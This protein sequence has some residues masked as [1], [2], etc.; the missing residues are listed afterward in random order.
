MT[1]L[2]AT[3][4]ER[5][6]LPATGTPAAS[7]GAGVTAGDVLAMLRRRAVMIIL[8][9]LPF[10]MVAVGLFFLVYI[11]F[12][13]YM[14]DAWVECLSDQPKAGQQL[15]QQALA[16]DL[17][18]RFINSQ[19]QLITSSEVLNAA[20]KT[21]EVRGT[22][23]FRELD[24]QERFLALQE[25]IGAG[26]MKN[27]NYLRVAMRCRAQTDPAV[28][29]RQVVGQFLNM[30]QDRAKT[31]FREELK[32]YKNEEADLAKRIADKLETIKAFTAT[33]PPG[34]LTNRGGIV[35]EQLAI[36]AEQVAALELQTMELEGLSQV[37]N[38]PSGPGVSAEDRQ[39]V[40]RDPMVQNL[41][42]QLFYIEQQYDILLDKFGTEHRQVKALAR[43]RDAVNRQLN[44][45]R[46]QRL[47]DILDFRREQVRTAFLNS[48]HALLLARDKL[49][50]A[51]AAQ[52]DLDRKMSELQTLQDELSALKEARAQTSA[53]VRDIERVVAD[54]ETIR[55][56]LAQ[57]A[58]DPLKRSSPHVMWLPAGV[59]LAFMFAV[60]LAL[61]L[62]FTDTSV[63]TPQDIVRHLN[64]P[65]LGMVPDVDDE[66]VPIDRVETAVRDAPHSMIVE[67][68]RTIRTNLQFSA[69]A[70]RQRTIIVTSALPEHGKTTIASNLAAS[71][72]QGGRRVLLV[73]A[74]FRRPT[75]HKIYEQPGKMGLSN[76]LVGDGAVEDLACKTD[77][78]NLDILFSGPI[79][80]NPAERLGSQQVHEVLDQALARYDQVI[81]DSPPVLLASDAIV[82]A[83]Y[84]DGVVMVCRA[85]ESSRGAS[86]R[87]CHLLTRVNAH[88]FGA[89][90]NAARVRRGG[91][92]RE[93]M[94]AFYDYQAEAL[95][96]KED[97]PALPTDQDVEQARGPDHGEDADRTSDQDETDRD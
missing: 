73:D 25:T 51:Q 62:E 97:Q 6:P 52:A 64:I 75:L 59:V 71:L 20:L 74:N 66:E 11:Y 24:P 57:Q 53:F 72:A 56:S 15:I 3:V 19:A 26:A 36:Y 43:R 42:N 60:G 63:R 17:H 69:S 21:P 88:I 96:E 14:A 35:Y 47:T 12:P 1:T 22:A 45:F 76:L 40:E 86:Q 5:I 27:T 44:Q 89:V 46:E 77:I 95:L 48:Q 9:W 82:L 31:A 16:K 80:P 67:A 8:L 30:V 13:T 23:W 83:T 38:D 32:D 61:L 50:E 4:Q 81:F 91:Y 55:V 49:T 39:V 2:P 78:A 92:Y 84:V 93:Q 65:V 33:L 41:S 94:A 10:S 87:A 70:E 34:G 68:F 7:T 79:P 85:K 37:H 90:L 18:E 58:T 29:V 54:R 28:I